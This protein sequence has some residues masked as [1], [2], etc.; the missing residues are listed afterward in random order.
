MYHTY[1]SVAATC[2]IWAAVEST[3]GPPIAV[4]GTYSY[5]VAYTIANGGCQVGGSH[6][7]VGEVFTNTD[8]GTCIKYRCEANASRGWQSRRGF[9]S[10]GM[11]G[12]IPLPVCWRIYIR[13]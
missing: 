3:V 4:P 9:S 5:T 6:H 13:L 1:L 7:A 8:S 11:S 10:V 12:R 2:L